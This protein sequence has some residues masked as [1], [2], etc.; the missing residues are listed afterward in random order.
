[1]S[2]FLEIYD[3]LVFIFLKNWGIFKESGALLGVQS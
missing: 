3:L 1:M 2:L